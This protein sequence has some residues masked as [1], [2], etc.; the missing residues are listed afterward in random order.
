MYQPGHRKYSG[1]PVLSESVQ[2][3]C[4]GLQQFPGVLV[5][6]GKV[7]SS[8]LHST[9]KHHVDAAENRRHILTHDY[10]KKLILYNYDAGYT[11]VP[12]VY[13]GELTA[14]AGDSV[15]TILN[16]IKET[17]GNYEYYYDIFGN[18]IFQEIRDYINTTEWRTLVQNSAYGDND[19]F[20]PYVINPTINSRVYDFGNSE[21]VMN[22]SNSPQL[23]MVKNDF[24]VWGTRKTSTGLELGCRYHLAIDERPILHEPMSIDIPIC[25]DTSVQDKVRKCFPVIVNHTDEQGYTVAYDRV[26]DLPLPGVVGK[27]YK[28]TTP[29]AIYTWVTDTEAYGNAVQN[30]SAATDTVSYAASSNPTP[31]YVELPFATYYPSGSF[32]L[33]TNTNWRNVLY[34]RGL[35]ASYTGTD[36]G[37][38]W[39]ELCNEW[40]KVYNIEQ[41]TWYDDV[42]TK[43][44]DLDWWLD[45]IDNNSILNAFSV[46]NIG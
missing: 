35:I 7:L 31:G 29:N 6:P 13:P 37:Y 2:T 3:H 5:H 39:A 23:S 32:V 12:F 9:D 26:D 34:F 1:S 24:V 14:N 41:D 22:Y 19:V 28:V 21:F 10:Y 36:T 15:C 38:Y 11:Y 8:I 16:K 40:P 17:L 20:L 4:K 44:T 25:F 43:P 45:I 33:S 30:M 18:F 27:Y 46:K 42:I